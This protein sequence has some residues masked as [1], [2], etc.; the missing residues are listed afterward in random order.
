M[1]S[2]LDASIADSIE[3]FYEVTP[4]FNPII[5]EAGEEVYCAAGFCG[6]G[7][8]HSPAVGKIMS[9]LITNG[10]TSI[11]ISPFTLSRFAKDEVELETLHV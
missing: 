2:L 6:H 9:E 11:D 5:D 8:M 1:P 10:K 7:F 4:D 3:S